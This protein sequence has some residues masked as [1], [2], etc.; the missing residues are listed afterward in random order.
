[1][2]AERYEIKELPTNLSAA[3]AALT[4]GVTIAFSGDLESNNYQLRL[5]ILNLGGYA[6]GA[7]GTDIKGALPEGVRDDLTKE[8]CE[9]V[10]S[11]LSEQAANPQAKMAIS[12]LLIISVIS[13]LYK[14]Y[15]QFRAK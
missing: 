13:T 2:G 10:A 8:E 9:L 3:A 4:D 14:L 5:I 12:P 15:Q 11:S 1:M 6:L 7:F